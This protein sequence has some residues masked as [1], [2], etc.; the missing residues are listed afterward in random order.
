MK[1]ALKQYPD[2]RA[3]LL[4]I[5]S[6]DLGLEQVTRTVEFFLENQT[7]FIGFDLAGHE[8]GFPNRMF[9]SAFDLLKPSNAKITVHAGES[10]NAEAVW[11]SIDL[12]GAKRIGHGIRSIDDPKLVKY[13]AEKKI[14]L[15]ICPTSNWL[16]RATPTWSDQPLTKFLEAGVPVCINTDDPGMFGITLPHEFEIARTKLGLS[17]KQILKCKENATQFSFLDL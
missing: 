14:C 16:T 9:K 10:S 17:E 12:L 4:C 7:S 8:A 2:M 1:R 11:E 5:A 6:R 15:E 3:G 13:L